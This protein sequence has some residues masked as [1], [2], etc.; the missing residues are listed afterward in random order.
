VSYAFAAGDGT[1]VNPGYT[2]LDITAVGAKAP[3]AD[4]SVLIRF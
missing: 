1:G 2:T 4:L 3:G